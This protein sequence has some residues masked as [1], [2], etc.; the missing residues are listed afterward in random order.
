[1]GKNQEGVENQRKLQGVSHIE[2]G[3]NA[4]VGSGK[5]NPERGTGFPGTTQ[6]ET[7][8]WSTC[9]ARGSMRAGVGDKR[10]AKTK[11]PNA[12]R[13]RKASQGVWP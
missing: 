11:K 10:A 6:T 3:P 13:P 1:M 4:Q 9:V 5:P 12:K 2:L 8:G 7:R